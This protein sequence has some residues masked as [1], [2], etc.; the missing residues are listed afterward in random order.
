MS[1]VECRMLPINAIEY[2]TKE[3]QNP[4]KQ[5]PQLSLILK[6]KPKNKLCVDKHKKWLEPTTHTN[7]PN[8]LDILEFQKLQKIQNWEE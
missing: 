8:N 4:R 1:Y 2:K 6:N 3:T 5:K 7:P